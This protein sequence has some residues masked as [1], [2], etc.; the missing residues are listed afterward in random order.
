MSG[1]PQITTV[2]VP[3]GVTVLINIILFTL[4]AREHFSFVCCRKQKVKRNL[5]K[6]SIIRYRQRLLSMIMTCF[7]NMG[8]TWI[9]AF[10]AIIPGDS[11]NAFLI[12]FSIL[13]SFQG[14]FIFITYIVLSK[15]KYTTGGFCDKKSN[16]LNETKT[17][18]IIEKK[19]DAIIDSQE[20]ESF[21]NNESTSSVFKRESN[22]I[23]YHF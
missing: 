8:L 7:V 1:I 23:V 21:Q 12:I 19:N 20:K 11:R 6:N 16:D 3:I 13:N 10:L 4:I 9:F 14:F 18:S 2:L 22:K 15:I 5:S 17:I